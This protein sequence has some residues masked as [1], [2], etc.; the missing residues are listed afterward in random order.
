MTQEDFYFTCLNPVCDFGKKKNR[1]PCNVID[2]VL[3]NSPPSLLIATV[4]K[5]ARFTWDERSSS[6]LGRDGNRPPELI[7]QDELHL[8]SSALGSIV[9]LYEVG[10]DTALMS[11]GMH[12]KYI[13]STATIT[14]AEKQIRTLF[15]RE[16]AIFPPPGIRYNDSYFAKTIPLD[17]KPGRLYVGYMAPLLN[18]QN[19]LAPL[20]STLLF[21]P[22][23]FGGFKDEY[24]YKDAWWTQI[25][26]HGSLK[27]VGVSRTLFQ[28]KI[29]DQLNNLALKTINNE[30]HEEFNSNTLMTME[31]LNNP[32]KII[33]E[34][35]KA[36][37]KKYWPSRNI[38]VE[39]L[40]SKQTAEDNAKIFT[41]LSHHNDEKDS[42]D[43][44][45]ATNMISVGLDV[46]RLSLM[47]INGQPL[48]TAEYIQASSR[49]GR[50]N[51][52]G[53][54]YVNYYKTQARSLSH[55]ENFRS[56][57]DSF[58]RFVEPSSL[59][60]FTYQAR[61]RALHAAFVIAIR[62][63]DIGLL[64]NELAGNFNHEDALVKKIIKLMKR[65]CTSA[66]G[67]SKET[68]EKTHNNIDNLLQDWQ[69]EVE[70]CN[71]N[72]IKLV[73]YSKDRNYSNLICNFGENN[74]R[75][76]PWQTLQSMRNVENSALIKLLKGVKLNNNE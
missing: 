22:N 65:R 41:Y 56:Y 36:I 40:T 13:A 10:I 30:I 62:H 48:T 17:E 45:L 38:R 9:G 37:V 72:K 51:I 12:T 33:D 31:E 69:N 54:V 61:I 35:V 46:Q 67:S 11:K 63:G 53:I 55:Y 70:Y 32:N 44:A 3:Y 64:Q 6:F 27:G 75:S 50:S 24:E 18:R 4:D 76:V 5:F 57:H 2:E 49:V 68:I 1:L 26:Y 34:D 43:V 52:P 21:A 73:Y 60:P 71:V 16:T 23:I 8:I 59:T 58:N 19:C 29:N 15:A 14:N 7:I 25:V 39:T 20:A 47:I 28:G 66:I 74:E 42:I